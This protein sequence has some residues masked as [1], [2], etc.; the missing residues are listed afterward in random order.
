MIVLHSG[1]K[2]MKKQSNE[3]EKDTLRHDVTKSEEKVNKHGTHKYRT[4][5]FRPNDYERHEIEQKIL[6]S[7]M[8]K[9]DYFIRSC[10]YN[11]VC[12]VGTKENIQK[13]RDE[14]IVLEDAVADVYES[15]Q[16]EEQ[17]LSEEGMDEMTKR[18]LAFIK[19]LIWYLEGAEYLWKG[20]K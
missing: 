11:R 13:I 10:I 15:L 5:S 9:N 20:D 6:V 1:E 19:A 7:G 8:S 3:P 18:Y 2:Q 14:M 12:V 17:L 16:Y 4:I